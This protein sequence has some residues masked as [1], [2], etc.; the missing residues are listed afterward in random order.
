MEPLGNATGC[1]LAS[2]N[3]D[4]FIAVRHSPLTQ[5]AVWI[6][7]APSTLSAAKDAALLVVKDKKWDRLPDAYQ[8]LRLEKMDGKNLLNKLELIMAALGNSGA[9]ASQAPGS[10]FN[11]L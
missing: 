9:H 5:A 8:E 2:P 4:R 11:M 10:S 1:L 3:G 6:S 7:S